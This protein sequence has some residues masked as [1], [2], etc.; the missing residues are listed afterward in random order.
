MSTHPIITESFSLTGDELDAGDKLAMLP[1]DEALTKDADNVAT[2]ASRDESPGTVRNMVGWLFIFVFV[3]L[4]IYGFN[5]DDYINAD[6]A[7]TIDSL[8]AVSRIVAIGAIVLI[9]F[10][11]VALMYMVRNNRLPQPPQYHLEIDTE[12]LVQVEPHARHTYF[13][14]AIDRYEESDSLFVVAVR[15]QRLIIPKRAMND[16]QVEHLRDELAITIDERLKA[17]DGGSHD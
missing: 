1:T 15:H 2:D 5:R 4:F 10:L 16:G 3:G 7:A 8:I 12:G 13:W 17:V 11:Y 9:G 6:N 14:H